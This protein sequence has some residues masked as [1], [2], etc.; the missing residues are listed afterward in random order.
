MAV[1]STLVTPAT[2]ETPSDAKS[3]SDPDPLSYAKPQPRPE[4]DVAYHTNKSN[5]SQ[6][7]SSRKTAP[8]IPTKNV[9]T[10]TEPCGR[11]KTFSHGEF[12]VQ[13]NQTPSTSMVTEESQSLD[14]QTGSEDPSEGERNKK[15][16]NLETLLE[17]EFSDLQV[18]NNQLAKQV[19]N[20]Q[21]QVTSE[22]KIKAAFEEFKKYEDDKVEQR[23]AKMDARLD[24]L[25]VDLDEELY[26]HMLTAIAGRRWVIGHGLRLA[27]MKCLESS[28]IRQAFADVVSAGLAKGMSEGLKYGIEHGKADRDLADIKAYDPEANSKLVKALQ[29]LKDLKYPMVDQL[30]RLK[31]A[32]MELIMA[33][34]HLN[35]D[36]GK[37]ALNPW[38]VKEEMLLEDAIVANISRAKKKKKCRV[39]CHA[40]GIGS[41]HHA[42]SDGIHVSAPTVVP[43]GLAIL[44]VDAATQTE[45]ADKEDE[46]HP[47]LQRS[48]SL[49]PVDNL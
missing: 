3:V 45:A 12:M 37:D 42:R 9:A 49:P 14:S 27:V 40:H 48:I 21:A 11:R 6:C 1:G 17:A 15:A 7:R 36:T 2:Q 33:S 23:C 34:L 16:K 8:E 29:D 46:P 47:R 43:Q 19:V 10:I 20:L 5:V 28:E 24:K 44:L 32:L 35:S 4:R 39:V 22:E 41:A 13:G 31:D 25:S 18:S 30:E 26:P 38:A